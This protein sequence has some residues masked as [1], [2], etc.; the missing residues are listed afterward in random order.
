MAAN[1]EFWTAICNYVHYLRFIV[2]FMILLFLLTAFSLVF[3]HPGTAAY[4]MALLDGALTVVVGVVAGL[5][6][7]YCN[8]RE[9]DSP[10]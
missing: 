4:A 10:F 8:N 6:M 1:G 9:T 7:W 5:M 3:G 2:L